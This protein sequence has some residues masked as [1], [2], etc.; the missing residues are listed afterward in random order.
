MFGGQRDISSQSQAIIDQVRAVLDAPCVTVLLPA[1][2]SSPVC[3][4]RP[5]LIGA[6]LR[7]NILP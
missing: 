5:A 3:P 4:V 2:L 6:C 7:S 1:A